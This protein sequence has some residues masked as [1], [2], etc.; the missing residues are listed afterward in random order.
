MPI[1]NQQNQIFDNIYIHSKEKGTRYLEPK[2]KLEVSRI[3]RW[4][5]HDDE[6]G[7]NWKVTKNKTLNV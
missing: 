3:S 1:I 2:I 7:Q 5:R 4:Q 6:N